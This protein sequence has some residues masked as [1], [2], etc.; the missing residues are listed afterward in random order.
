MTTASAQSPDPRCG[1]CPVR[2][3][4]ERLCRKENGKHPPDCPTANKRDLIEKALKLYKTETMLPFARTAAIVEKETYAPNPD[5]GVIQ[6]RHTRLVEIVNFAR[7]MG[8]KKLG[9]VFCIG[10]R[11]EAAVVNE[12]LETNGFTVASA[13]CKVGNV[14]KEELGLTLADQP[15]PNDPESMCNPI[16]QAE[17]MNDA[18]VDFNILLGLCVGHDSMFLGH[19]KAP[20]TVLA[21]KDRT[22]GHN[23]IACLY[24]YD[25]YA[26]YLKKPLF[27]EN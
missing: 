3:E 15:D 16:L 20:A 9:L 17:L 14:P 24:A 27:P 10:L 6:A 21:V 11:T 18:G 22:N 7:H 2:K 5:N 8:Y 26:G 4:S 1:A 12:V 25:S 13:I 19:I 23:P